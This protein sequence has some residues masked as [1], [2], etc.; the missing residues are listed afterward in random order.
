VF[1]LGTYISFSLSLSL[2]LYIYDSYG[3]QAGYLLFGVLGFL[4]VFAF[5][6]LRLIIPKDGKQLLYK[7]VDSLE[8]SEASANSPIYKDRNIST[9]GDD[10]TE[11][12]E[13]VSGTILSTT[14]PP[15]VI[16]NMLRTLKD[17]AFK[18]WY[19]YRYLYYIYSSIVKYCIIR[20][21]VPG[22][23]TVSIATGVRLG[24]GYIWA[25]YTG[26]FYSSLFIQQSSTSSSTSSDSTLSMSAVGSCMYSYNSTATVID[27]AV[28]V[29]GSDYPYC[30]QS[31]CSALSSYPWHNKG[32]D[33]IELEVYY[34]DGK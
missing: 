20:W 27:A 23:Y 22:V 7:R 12:I 25:G 30:V 34:N 1:N 17:I 9:T 24:G 11:E 28:S 31:Q 18:H 16:K 5:P 6:L 3:W 10:R 2:G 15:S 8:D 19:T 4:F 26:V 13:S 21:E 29:C 14:Q 33:S 32:M